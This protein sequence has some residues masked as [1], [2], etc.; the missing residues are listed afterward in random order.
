MGEPGI[1]MAGDAF[2]C[3]PNDSEF[4][5]RPVDA[6]PCARRGVCAHGSVASFITDTSFP[7]DSAL[8]A[9]AGSNRMCDSRPHVRPEADSARP[10]DTPG[11]RPA[12]SSR[13]ARPRCRELMR[14]MPGG[15]AARRSQS[16]PDRAPRSTG[17]YRALRSAPEARGL[18]VEQPTVA[19][20]LA[21]RGGP[22]VR[23]PRTEPAARRPTRGPPAGPARPASSAWSQRSLL[24]GPGVMPEMI[25]RWKTVKSTT[26]GALMRRM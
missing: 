1:D 17:E 2:C 18:H 21:R 15:K 23:A 13:G 6:L 11:H 12:G 14:R 20:A 4:P 16:L 8:P 26:S 25:C 5:S 19:G 24:H 3:D 10:R 7:H 22:P 9:G